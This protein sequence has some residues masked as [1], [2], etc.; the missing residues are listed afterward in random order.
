M[1][2]QQLASE[3]TRSQQG[4]P[5]IVATVLREAILRGILQG[6]QSLH[7]EEIAAQLGVSRLPVREALR[8]LEQ[9]GLVVYRLNRGATVTELSA[10][11]VQEIYEIRSGLESIALR[12]A[13]PRMTTDTFQQAATI[14]DIT[15]RETNVSRWGQ[16]NR[17]FHL[18]L[19]A[20]AQR[21]RLLS[22]I[23][24]F[25]LN[26]DRYLRMEM[27]MLRYKERSQQEHRRIL[28]AC[29]QRDTSTAVTLLTQHIEAAGAL[30]VTYLNQHI[31]HPSDTTLNSD[32]K[33]SM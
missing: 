17:E 14:L 7:Q 19:Y 5:E 29:Q 2:L 21:P 22:L 18:T 20:P 6:G 28:E 4:M 31:S 13:V 16:L 23:T 26:V 12:L 25:H 24:T 32:V 9:E 8:Q 27:V 30:L 10:T 1:D 15:D 11:E 33:Q 3:V